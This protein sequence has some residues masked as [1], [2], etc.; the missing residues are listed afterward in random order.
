MVEIED[1]NKVEAILFTT[2]KFMELEEIAK[3]C[4]IGSVGYVK[5]ILDE[6]KNDYENK[7]SSLH[8]LQEGTKYKL[9]IRSQYGHLANKLVSSSE[10]DN[11]TTKTLAIIA[12][13]QPIMQ[14]DVIK[15][16][17][18]KA[19][20]HIRILKESQ[21]ITSEKSGRT[22]VLKLTAKFY[23]Y[24]DVIDNELREKLI[25]KEKEVKERVAVQQKVVEEKRVKKQQDRKDMV[26]K[27][28]SVEAPRVSQLEEV[29][30]P[31][32]EEENKEEI[33]EVEQVQ[34]NTPEISIVE[35]DLEKSET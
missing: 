25:I 27:F 12:Y 13:K 24:F 1:K 11:P 22:R 30:E 20:D 18:N 31:F 4:G 28:L 33:K 5:E 15:I 19:Y 6:L 16:R 10:F 14:A 8:I 34:E 3:V 21:L 32:I 7:R 17:G 26:E 2:G 29:V 9:N 35:E 23:E